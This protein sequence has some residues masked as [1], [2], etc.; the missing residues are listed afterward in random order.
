MRLS[1]FAL[2]CSVLLFI[3]CGDSSTTPSPEDNSIDPFISYKFNGVEVVLNDNLKATRV[4]NTSPTRLNI[5][6]KV[7]TAN[8]PSL[9]LYI[10]SDSANFKDGMTV[11]A[12]K[13][14]I[15]GAQVNISIAGGRLYQSSHDNTAITI[16][17]DKASFVTGD[18]I[19]GSFSGT[20]NSGGSEEATITD[21]SFQLIIEDL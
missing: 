3:S 20:V 11:T 12:D 18:V 1:I 17:F 6:G 21:G 2:L 15:F 14:N 5:S 9:N 13:P 7:D 16:N 19:S 4:L 10:A 8:W